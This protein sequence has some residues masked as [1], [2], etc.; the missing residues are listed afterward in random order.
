MVILPLGPRALDEAAAALVEGRVVALPTDTVYGLAVDAFHPGATE[1]LFAAK[2]RPHDVDLPVLVASPDDVQRLAAD[3]PPFARALMDRWWPGPLTLVL[4]RRPHLDVDLGA[5]HD[6]VGVRCPA[7]DVVRE[8][9][10]RIGP[11]ATTSANRHGEPTPA[12]AL[13]VAAVFEDG[14]VAVV[15]DGGPCGGTP[16]TVL[17]VTDGEPRIL[18]EGA[19]GRDAL[20]RV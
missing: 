19:I 1:R 11:L 15:V 9:A 14:E 5:R 4:R 10:A 17:D 2:R 6:T 20:L 3:V 18:R 13:G 7:S 12:T 16:S 8:L